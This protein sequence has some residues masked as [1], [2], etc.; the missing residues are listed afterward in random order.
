MDTLINDQFLYFKKCVLPYQEWTPRSTIKLHTYTRIHTQSPKISIS[1]STTNKQTNKIIS[2]KYFEYFIYLWIA[3]K[4]RLFAYHFC[5]NAPY[6]PR[7]NTTRISFTTKKDFW[8]SVP[9]CD[10]L[11]HKD[12]RFV[13]FCT[14]LMYTELSRHLKPDRQTISII[15][16]FL[17]YKLF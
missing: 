3:L 2:L 8:T 5:K 4:Y 7:V 9:Q 10:N 17:E 14:N 1:P 13:N 12:C 15:P 11:N 6:A 16:K